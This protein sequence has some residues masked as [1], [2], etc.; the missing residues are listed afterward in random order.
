MIIYPILG[1]KIVGGFDA[2]AFGDRHGVRRGGRALRAH[3]QRRSIQR[4][5]GLNLNKF[6]NLNSENLNLNFLYIYN[7]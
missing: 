6:S 3:L 2:D 5:R 4:R 7:L 1:G